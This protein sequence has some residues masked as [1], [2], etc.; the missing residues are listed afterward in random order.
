MN[1]FSRFYSSLGLLI[2]LNLLIKPVWI[3]GIDLQVQNIIGTQAYGNY[4]AL[5]NLAIVF[6]FL[7][8]WGFTIF[9]N[10]SASA[11]PDVYLNRAGSYAI[12]KIVFA[13]IY[14]TVVFLIAWL[15]DIDDWFIVLMVVLIQVLT[16]FY[17][18][19]RSMITAMQKFKTDA[20]LSV[21]EK[22]LMILVCGTFI[23]FPFIAGSITLSRFLSVQVLALSGAVVMAL[24]ILIS[25]K[26]SLR[27]IKRDHLNKDLFKSALPFAMIVFLMAIHHRID[28]FLLER[29]HPDGNYEAGMYAAAY[30][31]LDAFLMP[32]NLVIAFLLPFIAKQH[33]AKKTFEDVA[34]NV[35]HFL[36][37]VSVGIITLGIILAPWIQ[38][39]LY[40]H[41]VEYGSVILQLTLL[42]MGGY[43]SI[44]V[45][46]TILTAT[47]FIRQFVMIIF[48]AVMLNI[49]LNFFLIPG[50]GAKGPAMAAIISQNLCGLY[51]AFFTT[52]KLKLS[53]GVGSIFIYLFSAGIY[54]IIIMA[55][56]Y[57][58]ISEWLLIPC[59]VI[60]GLLIVH[61]TK[62]PDW[63]KSMT[64]LNLPT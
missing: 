8:D 48:F 52:K 30:R 3:F 2:L 56:G 19:I 58:N 10:R 18:F 34:M 27:S 45:Y 12:L 13:F 23:Y 46:G 50:M 31:L 53:S 55:A 36:M 40:D 49:T 47:G 15:S 1:A 24:F 38:N 14:V 16:S 57:W 22:F 33:A 39:I 63:R 42:S 29:L 44:Q 21:L 61:F 4:F 62:T 43:T 25:L 54:F 51:L 35:R 37:M 64:D 28:A 60:A 26:V 5:L 6:S 11:M 32:G 9:F 7:T 17:L 20:W 59:C 41:D